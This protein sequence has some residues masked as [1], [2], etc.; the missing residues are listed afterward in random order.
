MA[1]YPAVNQR[2][3]LRMPRRFER[4]DE[5][6]WCGTEDREQPLYRL[7]DASHPAERE[8]GGAEAGDLAIGRFA[9]STNEVDG[10]RR[11]IVAVE[12]VVL[13]VENVS[14]AIEGYHVVI[15]MP[16]AHIGHSSAV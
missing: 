2:A 15:G 4:F 11:R 14:I 7:D 6:P 5:C 1:V 10:I 8:R 9:V 16:F 12:I 3:Q 13:R